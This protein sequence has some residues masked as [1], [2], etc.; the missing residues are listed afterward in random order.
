MPHAPVACACGLGLLQISS[1]LPAPHR[2]GG[3]GGAG[4]FLLWDM[5]PLPAGI[6][7][8]GQVG[9]G[10]S[11]RW[12]WSRGSRRWAGWGYGAGGVHCT[13]LGCGG[14]RG[15]EQ[16]CVLQLSPASPQVFFLPV[17]HTCATSRM[18]CL[19]VHMAYLMGITLGL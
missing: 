3:A 17:V 1:L 10:R 18:C 15:A 14:A 6:S 16:G 4:L 12:A 19:G 11:F 9:A 8:A 5:A 2:P 7:H 13:L